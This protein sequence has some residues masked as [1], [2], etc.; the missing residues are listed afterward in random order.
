[1]IQLY[2]ETL[3]IGTACIHEIASGLAAHG[4]TTLDGP[5]S[6][7]ALAAREGRL[8]IMVAGDRLAVDEITPWLAQIGPVTNLGEQP[9]QAQIMKMVNS[10]MMAANMVVASE[11]LALG[12]KAGLN[13]GAML[14][15]LAASTGNSRA[16][17]EILGSVVGLVPLSSGHICP[18]S[19][20]MSYWAFLRLWR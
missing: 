16:L 3:T 2:V 9:G 20:K 19:R 14:E 12:S 1:M 18:S 8:A 5:V 4:I 7:G 6:G 15:V 13:V 17:S 10:L 11:G